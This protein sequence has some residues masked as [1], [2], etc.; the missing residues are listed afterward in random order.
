MINITKMLSD[1]NSYGDKLRYHK[2][3]KNNTHGVRENMGPVVV[4]NCTNKCNLKCKHCYSSSTVKE[5]KNTLSTTEGIKLINDLAEFKVPVL[6]FSG[7][8][9]LLRDDLFYL[10]KE[11]TDKGIRVVISTNGTL[12]KEKT[13]N[14]LKKLK[15]SYVGVSIDGMEKTNDKFR[16]EK[17]A[18]Q[19]ALEGIRTCKKLSQ[20]VGLRFTINQA[21][22]KELDSVFQLVENENI[23]RICFYHLVYSG[24]GKNLQEFDLS[25]GEKK[26]VIDKI[27]YW[28]KRCIEKGNPK[29][30]LTVDNHTDG[31]Y[32]YLKKLKEDPEQAQLIYDKLVL[33]GGNRS[34]IAIASIDNKGEV[35]PDQFT[36]N[37]NLGNIRNRSFADI[38]TDSSCEILNKFRNRK[39]WIQGKCSRCKFMDICNGNLRARAYAVTGDIWAAD[40]A[41]YLENEEIK[42]EKLMS[43]GGMKR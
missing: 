3:C 21:N 22:Y 26:K 37:I 17:G 2:S 16:G 36:Q 8:E 43:D 35:H 9:P 29:E 41:C 30:I 23:P 7:G 42:K 31:V 13:V 4:W 6:L 27:I 20:K 10:I 39:K 28:A 5:D 40:P 12:L 19:K 1:F 15:V 34:G 25:S 24:R 33:S 18:F 32:L 14:K 11:A 38:W